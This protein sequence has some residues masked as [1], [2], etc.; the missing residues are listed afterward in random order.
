MNFHDIRMPQFMEAFAVGKPEFLTSCALTISGRE[1]RNL[2]CEHAKQRYLFKNC[3][4]SQLEFEQF[5]SF[6]RARR[7]RSFAF[8]FRD[9][10][11][12][13]V[14]QQFIA[15][16]DGNTQ[17]FSLIKLYTDSVSPYFRNITKPVEGSVRIYL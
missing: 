9:L 3:L 8:R 16:G 17:E 11:D 10:A 2:D 4:L 6:F 12:Y 7:G 1:L 5:N 14:K 15:K 13:Q